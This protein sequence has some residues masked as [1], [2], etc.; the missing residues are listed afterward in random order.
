M[1]RNCLV[2]KTMVA[3]QIDDMTCGGCAGSVTKAVKAVDPSAQVQ[4]DL[5]T[6]RVQIESAQAD[7]KA[8]QEAIEDAGYTPVPA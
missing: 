8:L 4:V 1:L 7:A 5:A 2:E 6:H 3:F